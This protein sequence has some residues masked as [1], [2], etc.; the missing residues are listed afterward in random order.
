MSDGSDPPSRTG[1]HRGRPLWLL[2]GFVIVALLIAIAA[3]VWL[4]DTSPPSP[5][6]PE[7]AITESPHASESAVTPQIPAVAYT[8][9]V[10]IEPADGRTPIIDEI[11]AAKRSI[12]LEVYI[13]TDDVILKALQRAQDRGVAVRV[14]LEEH[15][16]GGDGHQPATFARLEDGGIAVRWSN[17]LFRFS[18]IKTMVVDDE[19]A[20][21]MNQN[22]SASSFSKNR[23]FAVVTNRPDA[24]HTA[25]AIFEAD[26][27]RGGEPDPRPLVVS[28]TNARAELLALI[29]GANQSL[30]VY[31]E[32]LRDPEMLTALADA[33]SR[34]VA[35][36]VIVSPSAD[37]REARATL[38][39]A[40]VDLRLLSRLYVHAKVIV[41]DGRRAFIGSENISATS[42]DLNREL[43]IIVDDPVSLARIRST[44]DADFRVAK[45]EETP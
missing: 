44:F 2:V 15:P 23:E 41:A 12:D 18:H 39:A 30:D 40:G 33:E 29:A 24:V 32:V 6:R 43:G 5:L 8:T 21:I 4:R 26:W 34:G 17:P 9:G 20:L 28:P 35:V 13:L 3:I 45:P 22:L 27:T 19:V 7:A 38:V 42:L 1:E 25:A 31:A 14:M 37:F 10:F 36:R 16:F 11:D